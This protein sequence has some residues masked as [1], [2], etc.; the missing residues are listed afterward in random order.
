MTGV[1]HPG[2]AEKFFKDLFFAGKPGLPIIG[3][4]SPAAALG[5]GLGPGR[6]DGLKCGRDQTEAGGSF[7]IIGVEVGVVPPRQQAVTPAHFLQGAVGLHPQDPVVIQ[8]SHS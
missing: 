2:D 7:R 3:G 8:S 6:L 1:N 4:V 5:L